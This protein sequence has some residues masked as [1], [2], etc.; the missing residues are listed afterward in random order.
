MW[1]REFPQSGASEAGAGKTGLA[2]LAQATLARGRPM[3]LAV[4][5]VAAG[6]TAGCWQPL[7]RLTTPNADGVQDKFAAIDIPTIPAPKG[8]PVERVAVALRNALQYDLH[9]GD[10][11]FAPTYQLKVVISNSQFTA[12]L[13]PTTGRPNTQINP[14]TRVSADRARDRQDRRQRQHVCACRL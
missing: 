14:S 9:N 5:F 1:W 7:Y 4:V 12:Y 13:D 8:T 11:A 2:T 6:P 3:R 10:N